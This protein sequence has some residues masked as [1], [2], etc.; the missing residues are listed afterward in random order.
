MNNDFLVWFPRKS[1]RMASDYS[2]YSA[3]VVQPTF[4]RCLWCFFCSINHH[5]LKDSAK[6]LLR[7]MEE[8]QSY[9]FETTQGEILI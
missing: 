4:T 7:F 9:R 8:R 5:P 2:E 1:Y 3:G 6:L